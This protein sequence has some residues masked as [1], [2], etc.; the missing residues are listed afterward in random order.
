MLLME[1]SW[2][3]NAVAADDPATKKAWASAAMV[4]THFSQNTSLSI[5]RVKSDHHNIMVITSEYC[6]TDDS[7][8]VN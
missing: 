4:L 7:P 2:I 6:S 8:I 1:D 5:K 3:V